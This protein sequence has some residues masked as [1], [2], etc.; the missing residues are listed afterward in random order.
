MAE[1][2]ETGLINST[3]TMN[4]TL[5]FAQ[6]DIQTDDLVNETID[7]GNNTGMI[8]MDYDIKMKLNGTIDIHSTIAEAFK[9][10]VTTDII[11]AIQS[12]QAFIGPNTVVKEAE[13]TEAYGYLV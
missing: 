1:E 9:S 10:K 11:G 7:L 13:L 2:N 12:E 5:A 8:G 6:E 4:A 3:G